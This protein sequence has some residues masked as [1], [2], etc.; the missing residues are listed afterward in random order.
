MEEILE[1]LQSI[2]FPKK[3]RPNVSKQKYISGFCLG[4]TNLR[5]GANVN[6]KTRGECRLN[7]KYPKLLIMIDELMDKYLPDFSYTT[8]QINK[9]IECLPHFDKNNVGKSIIIGLGDYEDGGEL[10]IEGKEYNVKNKLLMFN[11][12][13]GHWVNPWKGDRYTLT[14]FTHTFKPPNPH[15]RG[16]TVSKQGMYDK[17]GNVV[18]EYV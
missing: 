6:Y 10:V 8:I 4:D 11:G 16:W 13:R 12:K 5:G 18:K 17:K 2:K 1:F 7:R 9:N 14:Y 15:F 3:P